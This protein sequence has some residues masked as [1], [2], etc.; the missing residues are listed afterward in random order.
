MKDIEATRLVADA[1]QTSIKNTVREFAKE[2]LGS[3]DSKIY[4]AE[5]GREHA[6]AYALRDVRDSVQSA[7]EESVGER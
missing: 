4:M 5:D 6:A 7:L 2:L 1:F 3:L